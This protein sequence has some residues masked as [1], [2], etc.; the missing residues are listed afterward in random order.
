[1]N[2]VPDDE[3]EA[4]Y[5]AFLKH[6]PSCVVCT[7]G[8]PCQVN[9]ELRAAAQAATVAVL[10]YIPPGE[11]GYR[12][13]RVADGYGIRE[14]ARVEV[15]AC[16]WCRKATED[17]IVVGVFPSDSG[18]GWDILACSWC[19]RLHGLLP[20]SDHPEGGWCTP[21]HRDRNRTPAGIPPA[22]P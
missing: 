9:D 15:G 1:M 19:V 6:G 18:P 3:D 7:A 14:V 4:D 22:M 11:Q 2:G 16:S 20:L 10:T 12:T 13:L 17:L 5:V 8:R 21:I